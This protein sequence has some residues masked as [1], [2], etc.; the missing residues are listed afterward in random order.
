[1][2]Q[3]DQGNIAF[4]ARMKG[5]PME[6]IAEKANAMFKEMIPV[7]FDKNTGLFM[8]IFPP[9]PNYISEDVLIICDENKEYSIMGLYKHLYNGKE[10]TFDLCA[11]GRPCF[12]MK[13]DYS[14]LTKTKFERT[15]KF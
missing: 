6:S 7:R 4:H 9:V 14:I 3:D 5:V 13:D 10:T 12:D 15:L 1:M 8:P 11:G 2:L